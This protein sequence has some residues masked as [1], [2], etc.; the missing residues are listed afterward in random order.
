[1]KKIIVILFGLVSIGI[2]I[3][4]LINANALSKRCTMKT[5]GTVVDIKVEENIEDDEG[6]TR[7]VYTYYP[8]IEYDAENKT[9]KKQSSTGSNSPKYKVNDRINILYNPNNI[10]EFI[11][12]GDK[13]SNII[14]IIFIVVGIVVAFIGAIKRF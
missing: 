7:T 5:V 11:I 2:G 9:V 13:S 3:F 14:G 4:L 6:I 10:E 12:E 1:M 8:V